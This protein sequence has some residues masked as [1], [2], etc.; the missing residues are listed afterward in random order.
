MKLGELRTARLAAAMAMGLAAMAAGVTA[1]PTYAAEGGPLFAEAGVVDN[2]YIVILREP[3]LAMFKG[4]SKRSA[5]PKNERGKVDFDSPQAK[6]YEA[7]LDKVQRNFLGKAS[8]MLGRNIAPAGDQYRFKHALN[9]FALALTADEA[10]K[11]AEQPE[12]LL[13]EANRYEYINDD[14]GAPLINAPQVWSG[15]ATG[16]AK[17]GEGVIVGVIDSGA[18]LGSPSFAAV[19]PLDLVNG[20]PYRHVNPYGAGRFRGFCDPTNPLN[21]PARD[22]CNDKLIAGWDYMD[23]LLPPAQLRNGRLNPNRGTE[24]SG[25]EDE[26]SHGSHTASTAAGNPRTGVISGATVNLTGVAPRANVII[27]DACY[28]RFDNVGPCPFAATTASINQAVADGVDVINYSIGGG[29]APWSDATSLAFLGAHNAGVFISASAGN[30]GP[31]AGTT[32]HRQPWVTT[33]AASTTD[34]SGFGFFAGYAGQTGAIGR[35]VV[36]PATG[37]APSSVITATI[38]APLAVSP[39]F[40]RTVPPLPTLNGTPDDGCDAYPAGTFTG[41]IALVRRGTCGFAVK[42]DNARAAGAVAVIISNSGIDGNNG[43]FLGNVAGPPQATIPTVTISFTA[44]A[45]LIPFAA[46]NPTTNYEIRFPAEGVATTPDVLAAF[47]SR[48]PSNFEVMKPDV[49]GPG[50]AILADYARFNPATGRGDPAGNNNIGLL[51]GTSMSSPHNAGAAALLASL[52][53]TWT[54]MEIKSALVTTGVTNGVLKETGAPSDPFDRGGGRVD[55]AT[56]ARVGLVMNETAA[57]FTAANPATGGRPEQL[58]MPHFQN[59]NAQGTVTFNR[60]VKSVATAPVTYTVSVAGLP[61]GI[62]TTSASTFTIAPGATQALSLSVNVTSLSQSANTFGQLVLTPNTPNLPV[63]RL[64]IAVRQQPPILATSG[65]TVDFRTTRDASSTTFTVANAGGPGLGY[66][67]GNTTTPVITNFFNQDVTTGSGFASS[68]YSGL[69]PVS[70]TWLADDFVVASETPLALFRLSGFVLPGGEVLGDPTLTRSVRLSIFADNNGVPAGT[71]TGGA[72]PVWNY[73]FNLPANGA[74]PA[75]V[76]LANNAVTVDLS[77]PAVPDVT[78]Q[79]GRYWMTAAPTVIGDGNL[80]QR[81]NPSWFWFTSGRQYTG[82]GLAQAKSINTATATATWG[83]VTGLTGLAMQYV[84][85]ITCGAPWLTTTPS[86]GTLAAGAQQAVTLNINLN[87]PGTYRANLCFSTATGGVP[88]TFSAANVVPI[89]VT[90]VAEPLFV[91]GYVDSRNVRWGERVLLRARVANATLPSSTGVAVRADLRPVGGP[92]GVQL[93]DNGQNGDTTAGDG[94]YTA[95]YTL[96]PRR[97]PVGLNLV[98][99]RAT[100]NQGRAA[101]DVI[102]LDVRAH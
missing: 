67:F 21:N 51:S 82:A 66:R 70:G 89:T 20:Q 9:G 91:G 71:P 95:A 1:T 6:A 53:P 63:Q 38:A 33:V 8:A 16:V 96:P 81:D 88:A 86:T 75:G 13:V 54:P 27:Y 2:L 39:N 98:P 99:V 35:S 17:R 87:A 30:S 24:G 43:D 74:L 10:A 3:S 92:E 15:A 47:S 58:N 48:G 80:D 36:N 18:N 57:N 12:V 49:T 44:A 76:S 37:G 90:A 73:T 19:S 55:V 97:V 72:A 68:V 84:G 7:H 14:R 45:A 85:A 93:L 50:V 40:N 100:D 94:I 26:N 62:A 59:L 64:P 77:S 23:P 31:G 22:L 11:L 46:A 56:A 29:T 28:T 102:E 60:T 41:K 4:D 101:T 42:V 25:F 61:A 79:P 52:Y 69:T 32:G 5:L 34:R 78:L 65:L 83:D